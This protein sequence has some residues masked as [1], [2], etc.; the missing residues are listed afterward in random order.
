MKKYL[1]W[2]IGVWSMAAAMS[3]ALFAQ[4]VSVN[5]LITESEHYDQ[6]E[7][8]IEGEAIGH[9]MRRGE[10]AWLN[11]LDGDTSIGVWAERK[12]FEAIGRFG[13]Y[14]IIG[15]RIRVGGIYHVSCT[16]H[17]GDADI[18]AHT[19]EVVALGS[20]QYKAPNPK[21][22]EIIVVLIGILVCLYIIKILKKRR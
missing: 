3:T 4:S 10:F 15:D 2:V 9:L 17:G 8:T 16:L 12:L 13:R 21:K 18:H 22:K 6:K 11:V 14:G 19:L 1:P 20:E 7:V 5:E